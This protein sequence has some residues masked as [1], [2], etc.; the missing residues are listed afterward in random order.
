MTDRPPSDRTRSNSMKNTLM[1]ALS[2]ALIW[3]AVFFGSGTII[4]G[5]ICWQIGIGL[6]WSLVVGV[7]ALAALMIF[8]LA[9]FVW[10]A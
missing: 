9:S 10:D 8:W 6:Q 2:K 7:L 1:T 3:V 5:V 4:G